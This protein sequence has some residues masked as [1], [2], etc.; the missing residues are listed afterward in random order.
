MAL[1][2]ICPAPSSSSKPKL[3]IHARSVTIVVVET[4]VS[5]PA[6]TKW[7]GCPRG[8]SVSSIVQPRCDPRLAAGGTGVPLCMTPAPAIN[9]LHSPAAQASTLAEHAVVEAN[10]YGLADKRVVYIAKSGCRGVGEYVEAP[11]G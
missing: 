5:H 11:R 2:T 1:T 6:F 8:N 7:I 4:S 10:D 9:N 3:Q